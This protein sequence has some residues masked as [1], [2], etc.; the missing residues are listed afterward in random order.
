MRRNDNHA[1]S[2]PACFV[3]EVAQIFFLLDQ[4]LHE[5]GDLLSRLHQ[6]PCVRRWSADLTDGRPRSASKGDEG[7]VADNFELSELHGDGGGNRA[8]E[9]I[10]FV[11]KADLFFV[12]RVDLLFDLLLELQAT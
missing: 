2:P 3:E 12:F 5:L 1:L 10:T 9:H 4:W 11:L 7:R 8:N 6:V